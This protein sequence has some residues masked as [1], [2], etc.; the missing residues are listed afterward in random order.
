M[1]S[2]VLRHTRHSRLN[3]LN[4]YSRR[5][6]IDAV[7]KSPGELLFYSI[8]KHKNPTL[9]LP[10]LFAHPFF[11]ASSYW[12]SF[13]TVIVGYYSCYSSKRAPSWW[14]SEPRTIT[15]NLYITED[16][17]AC[18]NSNHRAPAEQFAGMITRTR[19]KKTSI[20]RADFICRRRCRKDRISLEGIG[21]YSKD[22]NC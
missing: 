22:G 18:Q 17:L 15:N 9:S 10:L 5:K 20:N 1:S 2:L 8:L 11:F 3:Y 14:H 21:L 12:L 7:V 6:Y 4:L 16:L 13:G 19:G